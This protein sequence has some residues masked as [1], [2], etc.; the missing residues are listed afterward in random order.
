MSDGV[1]SAMSAGTARPSGFY[2]QFSQELDLEQNIL[3][4]ALHRALR[5]DLPTGVTDLCPGYVNLYVDFDERLIAASDV[6]AWVEGHL[7][8]FAQPSDAQ[9]S[10]T[11]PDQPQTG[12]ARGRT[13]LLP[14]RYDGAD[15]LEVA[16]RTGLSQ[17]AVIEAHSSPEY[18]VYALGF[19]PGFPFL[20]E[21]APVLRLPRRP[22]PRPLVPFNS[23]AVANAQSCVY[24]LPSPGG[25]NLLGTALETLYDPNRPEP[26][27]ISPG[28]K[29]RFQASEGPTPTLPA[30][31]EL[32]SPDPH[33][34][35]LRVEEA[36]LLDLMMDA[37]RFHQAHHGLARSGP[38]DE[39][40]ARFARGLVGNPPG[41]PLLE[42]TLRGP[43]F[44]A[45]RDLT[46]GV[47]GFGMRPVGQPMQES[48]RLWAGQTLR[49]ESTHLGARAYLAVA[50]GFE[51]LP[52]LGSSSTDLLGRVGRPLKVGDVLGLARETRS[53]VG[54]AT[55]RLELPEQITLR[56][57]PG[58]QATLEGLRA[59]GEAYFRVSSLDRMGLR[60]SQLGGHPVPGAEVISEATPHGAV[61]VTPAGEAIVLLSDRGRIGGYSKP[62]LIH[63]LD[64]PLAAQLRPGQSVRFE[65]D[66][67]GTPE[68]WA[69]R[70]Y[71]PAQLES[72]V[73]IP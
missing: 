8:T 40:S 67:S 33:R 70:W 41:T 12:L 42:L 47:A 63:P 10:P 23:V 58:P 38:L 20:G 36:G 34:P 57:L 65:P 29:V 68:Q 56:L 7:R 30:V 39:R 55:R 73:E 18:H 48:F 11:G 64:L 1:A 28:D 4:H 52:F 54:F 15:L 13:V 3:L 44:T 21:V 24:A 2:L 72:V 59:L 50:G 35:A 53:R 62:A 6:H 61:Q 22:T 26:F 25:W 46:L 69:Q 27:L 14:V 31:R 60:L 45:L 16:S 66:L 43:V 19:T 37:G 9:P 5:Q 71:K 32:W 51:T 17:A 49:F